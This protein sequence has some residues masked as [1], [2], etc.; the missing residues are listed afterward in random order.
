[1]RGDLIAVNRAMK[2]LVALAY[3]IFLYL[4]IFAFLQEALE[5]NLHS[6][7]LPQAL[8]AHT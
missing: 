6:L 4:E 3:I 8:A 5:C 2:E 1:M 7:C